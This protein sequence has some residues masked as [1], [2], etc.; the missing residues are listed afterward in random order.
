MR[1]RIL[2]GLAVAGALLL[3][4]CGLPN[5]DT[6]TPAGADEVPFGLLEEDPPQPPTTALPPTGPVTTI[7]LLD[8]SGERLIG[9]ERA[10]PEGG[11]LSPSDIIDILLL[12]ATASE[13]NAGVHTELSRD[14]V[15]TVNLAGGVANVD[16]EEEFAELD[17]AT[18]RRALAQLVYT[19]TSRPGVGRVSFTLA[20]QPIEVPRGDGTLTSGSVSRDSYRELA[21]AS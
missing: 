17:G 2:A 21:P 4:A 10:V 12:G 6:A 19:L 16:L 8:P 9:V 18:Q 14:A 13:T 3:P 11:D 1:L 5:E 7:Y 15:T 20:G